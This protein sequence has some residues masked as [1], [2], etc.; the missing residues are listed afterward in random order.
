MRYFVRSALI[1][2]AVALFIGCGGSQPPIAAPG[3]LQQAVAFSQRPDSTKYSVVYSFGAAPDG[4]SPRASVM[5]VGDTFYGPTVFGGPNIC[6]SSVY[7]CGTVFSVTPSG[8]ENV[9]H[10][11]GKGTDGGAPMAAL[12]YAGG[13]LFGT[14]SAGGANGN[15]TVFLL[16]P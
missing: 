9:L 11:F 7:G 6:I 10:S 13:K 8:A 3:G 1:I 16:T 15:G 12:Y 2:G 5:E 14:T 4:A